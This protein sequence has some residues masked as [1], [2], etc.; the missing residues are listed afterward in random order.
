[1]YRYLLLLLAISISVLFSPPTLM[2]IA[3]GRIP[4]GDVIV[5]SASIS[6]LSILLCGFFA[7]S[8]L[9]KKPIH[10]MLSTYTVFCATPFIGALALYQVYDNQQSTR[11]I[12]TDREIDSY[13][14]D[15]G[16][17]RSYKRRIKI[18]SEGWRSSVDYRPVKPQNELI[19]FIGDS[20][21]FGVVDQKDMIDNILADRHL[22]DKSIIYNLGRSGAG[23][24]FYLSVSERYRFLN[25]SKILLFVYIGNDFPR[26]SNGIFSPKFSTFRDKIKQLIHAV[27]FFRNFGEILSRK[28]QFSQINPETIASLVEKDINVDSLNPFYLAWIFPK[29]KKPGLNADFIVNLTKVFEATN[30]SQNSILKVRKNFPDGFF[31]VVMIPFHLQVSQRYIEIESQFHLPIQRILGRELQDALLKWASRNDICMIDLLP[32]MQE[33]EKSSSELLFMPLNGHLNPRGNSFVADVL[34]SQ[35]FRGF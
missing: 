17:L 12:N 1:M 6:G 24:D 29:P 2:L 8:I 13:E 3:N 28:L 10:S 25:P 30:Y 33:Y 14:F 22:N 34:Y 27:A 26:T 31:C 9:R 18:N 32:A 11:D 7:Y 16:K 21:V 15:G 35:I 23:F 5:F 19:F 20:F 4:P